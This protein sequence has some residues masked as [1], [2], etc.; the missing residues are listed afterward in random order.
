MLY[1]CTQFTLRGPGRTLIGV[2][3]PV[4]RAINSAASIYQ[5]NALHTARHRAFTMS[6]MQNTL[7]IF[8][9]LQIS[10]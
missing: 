10:F 2:L 1:L 8:P 9:A 5:F 7:R 3:R 4:L 6:H